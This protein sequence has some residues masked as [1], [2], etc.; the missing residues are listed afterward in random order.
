[1]P[2]VGPVYL[3]SNA[4]DAMQLAESVYFRV[5]I[6]R[7]PESVANLKQAMQPVHLHWAPAWA[8]TPAQCTCMA[9]PVA[10]NQTLY[11]VAICD[12]I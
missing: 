4:V 8:S 12:R 2:I 3:H 10:T 11:S 1:M 9:V 7:H 5:P 6:A